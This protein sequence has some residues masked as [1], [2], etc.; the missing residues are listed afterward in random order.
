MS[1]IQSSGREEGRRD[2]AGEKG[3]E[4]VSGEGGKEQIDATLTVILVSNII[5]LVFPLFY[6]G[7]WQTFQA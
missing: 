2:T 4:G 7:I 6:S 1:L 3:N 5:M